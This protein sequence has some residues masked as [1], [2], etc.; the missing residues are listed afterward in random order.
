M[1]QMGDWL[2][3]H[4]FANVIPLNNSFSMKQKPSF[5]CCCSVDGIKHFRCFDFS[6]KMAFN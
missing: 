6:C 1:I 2:F 4:S 3:F 5:N